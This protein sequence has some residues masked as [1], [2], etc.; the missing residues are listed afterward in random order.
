MAPFVVFESR[1]GVRHIPKKSN[2]YVQPM[3]LS[4]LP[5][6]AYPLGMAAEMCY[7]VGSQLLCLYNTRARINGLWFG[8]VVY[9]D[10]KPEN[11]LINHQSIT[12]GDIGSVGLVPFWGSFARNATI[13]F[14]DFF[15]TKPSR[16]KPVGYVSIRSFRDADRF[17][18]Y[19]LDMLFVLCLLGD[20]QIPWW[21]SGWTNGSGP[22]WK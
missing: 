17:L 3:F 12:L 16:S 9:S 18:T 4:S 20:I 10:V 14:C 2:M 5:V 22:S 21:K 7:R 13:P 11:V 19:V 6:Q 15:E 8:N 1:D